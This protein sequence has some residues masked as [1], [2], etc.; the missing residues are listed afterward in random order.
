ME[1]FIERMIEEEKELKERILKA[2]EF[3]LTSTFGELSFIEK[4]LLNEQIRC[5]RS[6]HNC[7][8]AR[9]NFYTLVKG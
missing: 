5:M 9:I 8:Q 7:L 1:A 4:F 6:Y 3:T 2:R